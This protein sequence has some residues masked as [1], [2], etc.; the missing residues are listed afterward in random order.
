M[1]IFWTGII[2]LLVTTAV[3]YIVLFSFIYY[4]HLKK[5][6]FVAVPAIFAFEFFITGF[7]IVVI[8]SFVLQYLPYI[9]KLS[10]A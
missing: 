6:S 1:D 2:T 10:G 4:W 5:I 7:F 3:F 9:F 8:V